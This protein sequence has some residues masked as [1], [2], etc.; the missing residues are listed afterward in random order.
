MFSLRGYLSPQKN[1]TKNAYFGALIYV[2]SE[3]N[4]S[5]PLILLFSCYF[6]P[7]QQLHISIPQQPP[8][9]RRFLLFLYQKCFFSFD[10]MSVQCVQ[11]LSKLVR[12]KLGKRGKSFINIRSNYFRYRNMQNKKQMQS[13]LSIVEYGKS[14]QSKAKNTGNRKMKGFM[15]IKRKVVM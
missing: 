6:C 9:Q 10:S 8:Q 5:F 11:T 15:G 7:K 4:T 3:Y 14:F 13:D 1:H 12:E 2:D